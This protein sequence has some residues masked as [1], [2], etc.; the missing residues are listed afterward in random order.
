MFCVNN[1][2]AY[3][4]PSGLCE[5]STWLDDFLLWADNTIENQIDEWSDGDYDI[6]DNLS[7][8]PIVPINGDMSNYED[9]YIDWDDIGGWDSETGGET[10][11]GISVTYEF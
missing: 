4:D 6:T 8:S 7:I 10:G 5:E 1:P 3:I 11:I 9:G 2:V